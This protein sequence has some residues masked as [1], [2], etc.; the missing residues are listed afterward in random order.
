MAAMPSMLMTRRSGYNGGRMMTMKRVVREAAHRVAR[1]VSHQVP[2]W[3]RRTG[4]RREGRTKGKPAR[5]R[6]RR[7]CANWR[8]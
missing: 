3:K 1:R 2:D 7:C 5:K 6:S 8:P 4:R